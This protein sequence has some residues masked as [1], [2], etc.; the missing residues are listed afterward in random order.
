MATSYCVNQGSLITKE[1]KY[2]QGKYHK[3][4]WQYNEVKYFSE[5]KI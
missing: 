1:A 5:L 4:F 3:K 2:I